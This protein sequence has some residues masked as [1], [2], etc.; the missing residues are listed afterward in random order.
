MAPDIAAAPDFWKSAG[1]HLLERDEAGRLAVTDDF[2]RAYFMR[3]EMCPVEESCAAEIAL[4]E[5]LMAEPRRAVAAQE[6]GGIA[7]PDAR[8]NYQIVLRFRDHLLASGTLEDAYVSLLQGNDI[9]VPP[10]FIDQMVQ[11]I[12]R[13][14]LDGCDD[15]LRVRAAELLFRSQKVTLR[16]GAIMVADEETVEMYATTG[17]FGSLGRLLVEAQTP[18]RQV[19]LDVLDERSAEVY[20]ER[21]DRYDTVLDLSFARPGLDAF[22]RVL[23]AWIRHFLTV[24]VSIQPVQSIRGRALGLACGPRARGQRHSERSLQWYGRA[25]RATGAAAHAVPP[26]LR[27]QRDHAAGHRRPSGLSGHGHD[28]SQ[29]PEAQAAESV[30]QFAARRSGLDETQEEGLVNEDVFNMSIRK[31]LKKVGVTSQREIEGAVR[32]RHR[33]RQA[34]R[35]REFKCQGSALRR[36]HRFVGDRRRRDCARIADQA[37]RVRPVA[38]AA[39]SRV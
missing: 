21:S 11:V 36:R 9:A 1:Y 13:S 7:D 25:G 18:T 30:V 22:C 10:L 35:E 6:L 2:L 23:E 20:W 8:E 38:W 5:T 39:P 31:F 26:G 33:C 16:D 15:P 37:S 29:C 14:I 32:R 3:P 12:L 34:H 17:G 24:D 27:R 28:H 19:E 4:H